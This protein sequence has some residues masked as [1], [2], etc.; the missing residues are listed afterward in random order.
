M[1]LSINNEDNINY[2]EYIEKNVYVALYHSTSSSN[3]RYTF[4]SIPGIMPRTYTMSYY[5]NNTNR[6]IKGQ[7]LQYIMDNKILWSEAP[8]SMNKFSNT[9]LGKLKVKSS[10]GAWKCRLGSQLMPNRYSLNFKSDGQVK[11]TFNSSTYKII[12]QINHYYKYTDKDTAEIIKI[13]GNL[14]KTSIYKTTLWLDENNKPYNFVNIEEVLDDNNI[15]VGIQKSSDLREKAMCPNHSINLDIWAD[16]KLSVAYI[17]PTNIKTYD[18]V[19]FQSLNP[20]T[21]VINFYGYDVAYTVNRTMTIRLQ[22]GDIT[23]DLTS[24]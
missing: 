24:G 7:Y 16:S 5:N 17:S 8:K 23:M 21:Y 11:F 9:L 22:L 18:V 15:K 6:E 10:N 2:M 12:P 13:P 4:T 3:V 19:S 20:G 14:K 1:I